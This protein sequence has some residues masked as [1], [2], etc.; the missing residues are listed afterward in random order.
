MLELYESRDSEQEA[1]MSENITVDEHK[2]YEI[3]EIL[4]KKNV[5]GELWYKMKW[6]K[7]SQEYNQWIIYEDLEGTSDLWDAYDK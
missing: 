4:D 7:W 6:L 2:E 5:K 1:L 3:E